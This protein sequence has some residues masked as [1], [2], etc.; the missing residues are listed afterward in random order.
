[1][2]PPADQPQ[3]AAAFNGGFKAVNGHYGIMDNGLTLL[4][5]VPGIATVAIYRD[6]SVKMGTWNKDLFPSPNMIA[7]RQN[8]PPLIDAGQINPTLDLGAGSAWG[9]S[10]N[11]D[12]TWR[13][14]LGLT[15]DGRTLI[16]AVGN[17]T[18]AKF[19]ARALQEAGAY[20]GMQLDINQYYAQFDAYS[21]VDS[22]LVS[23]RL[24]DQMT[25]YSGEYLAPS[26]RDFFYV[27]LR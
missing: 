9:F 6:G 20:W 26:P 18:N 16:Y 21:H 11:A 7:F 3:L 14:G 22:Q 24:L 10:H 13:T 2:V 25:Q 15:Q 8:C 5:P 17:G 27:T 23:Q 12:I 1:M 4:P 19:L